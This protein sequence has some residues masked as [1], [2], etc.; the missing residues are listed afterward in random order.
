MIAPIPEHPFW[1]DND[2]YV[3]LERYMARAVMGLPDGFW[4][5][6]PEDRERYIGLKVERVDTEFGSMKI[7]R[8]KLL[9]R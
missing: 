8:H 2:S 7:L 4:G 9:E 3:D 5:W 1:S 6:S